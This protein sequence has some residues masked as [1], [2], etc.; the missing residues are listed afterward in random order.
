MILKSL[1]IIYMYSKRQGGIRRKAVKGG[2]L[3]FMAPM[4]G[5]M[6][7]MNPFKML[8]GKGVVQPQYQYQGGALVQPQYQ[9]QG[10][11]LVQPQ[12]QYKGGAL[13]QPQQQY[14]G[15]MDAATFFN[16]LTSPVSPLSWMSKMFGGGMSGGKR[17]RAP[18]ARGQ[19][20][21]HLMRT[22]GMTLGQASKF[23]KSRGE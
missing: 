5:A 14:K 12:Y 6:G 3:P 2:F 20:V 16:P 22:Q 10:G 11:A 8:M 15:G 1:F 4:M 18:S 9:Y 13:V 21:A 23:L 17:K 7:S 19:K